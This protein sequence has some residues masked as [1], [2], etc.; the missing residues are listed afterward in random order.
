MGVLVA[1]RGLI[2][3]AEVGLK[4]YCLQQYFQV[5]TLTS[6]IIPFELVPFLNIVLLVFLVRMSNFYSV[7]PVAVMFIGVF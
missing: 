1:V 2:M 4:N 5:Y 3:D 7:P 6:W